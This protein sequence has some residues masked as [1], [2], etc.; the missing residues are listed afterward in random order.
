MEGTAST[1]LHVIKAA[2]KSSPR[3]MIG[4]AVIKKPLKSALAAFDSSQY[5]GAPLLGL[6]GLVVKAHG[7]STEVE[8]ANAVNQCALF[9][10]EDVNGKIRERMEADAEKIRALKRAA[11]E[12]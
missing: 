1:L 10:K 9:Y 8:F 3:G 7:S 2:L 5:G 6:K 4:G 11:K 12:S